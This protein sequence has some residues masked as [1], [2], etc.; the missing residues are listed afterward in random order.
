MKLE[1]IWAMPNKNTFSILPIKDLLEEEIKISCPTLDPFVEP[2]KEDALDL[3]KSKEDNSI[4]TGLYDPPYSLRQLK[5]V[6]N[7]KGLSLEQTQSYWTI[8]E[9]EWTRIIKRGGKL[10]KLGW[11]SKRLQGFKIIRI[12]LVSHG[13]NHNDTICTVQVRTNE[14][15]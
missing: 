13:G 3:M 11:N 6:Y 9:R 12:L 14:E 4:Q 2:Y 7:N 5:E 8:L 1:R 15:E 10:I